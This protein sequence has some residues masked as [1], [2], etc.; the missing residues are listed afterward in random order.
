MARRSPAL[1]EFPMPP[2]LLP[3]A[4]RKPRRGLAIAGLAGFMVVVLVVASGLW[5]RNVS[6][7]RLK[8][9]TDTQSVPVVS[10]I[11]PATNDNKS[12]LDLPGRLEAYAR[13]DLCPRQRLP[14]GLVRR[15]R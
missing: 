10:V 15:Y 7:A 4:S 9:W 5:T 14:E 2:E 11:S 1:P 13:A 12:S 6:Q 3:G 8:E